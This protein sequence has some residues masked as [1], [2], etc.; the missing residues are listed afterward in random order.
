MVASSANPVEARRNELVA[1]WQSVMRKSQTPQDPAVAQPLTLNINFD[2]AGAIPTVGMGGMLKIPYPC[3]ILSCE[4][5]AGTVGLTGVLPIAA[6][7]TVALGITAGPW[8][9]GS[10]PLTGSTPVTMTAVEAAEFAVTDWITELQPADKITYALTAFTGTATLLT[11]ILTLRKLDVVGF[12]VT[13]V[14]SG[15]DTIVDG[16]NTVVFRS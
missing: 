4:M 11:V 8:S 7:A 6:T 14:I 15:A 16:S 9:G 10:T 1:M 3:R 13:D 12:G 2:G 5:F